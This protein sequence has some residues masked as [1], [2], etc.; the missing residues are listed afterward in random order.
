[1]GS[2]S[3][4]SAVLSTLEEEQPGEALSVQV[5]VERVQERLADRERMPEA[6]EV[7]GR[8]TRLRQEGV[9]EKPERGRYALVWNDQ[10]PTDE[11]ARLVDIVEEIAR[12]EAL[13]RTVLWDATPYLELA[14]D[15]GPGTR[16]VVEA[17]EAASLQDEVEVRWP[18]EDPPFT[19]TAKPPGPLGL[20]LWEPDD[21]AP[22]RIP[23]GVLFVE[24]EKL[25]ATGLTSRGYRAPFPERVLAEFLGFEG[26]AEAT[27]IVRTIRDDPDTS[28]DRLWQ[29][30]VTLGVMEDF[31]ALLAADFDDLRPEMQDAFMGKLPPVVQTVL[32]GIR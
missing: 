21:P 1:M 27:S 12:P 22:Y 31:M 8:L 10:D 25:G 16:L 30:A 17:K 2:T 26:P 20:L 19:W 9:L 28:F 24:R 4:V 5:V 15:G 32:G 23:R 13:R 11:L 6:R 18:T 29:A 14:E 3:V 7:R